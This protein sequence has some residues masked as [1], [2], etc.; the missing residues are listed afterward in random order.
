M[1]VVYPDPATYPEVRGRTVG[2]LKAAVA[3]L[4]RSTADVTMVD[5]GASCRLAVPTA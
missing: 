1:D 3:L 2:R 4:S 5:L